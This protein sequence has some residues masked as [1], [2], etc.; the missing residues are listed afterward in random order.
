MG[1]PR[2]DPRGRVAAHHRTGTGTARIGYPIGIRTLAVRA[3]EQVTARMVRLTLA[4]PE[5]AGFHSY[6][7]DDHVKIVFPD[8]DGTRR[9]PVGNAEQTL[10]WPHPLPPA[11]KYTVRRHDPDAGELDLDFVLHP[12]GLASTWV[13]GVEPGEPVTVAGPPG[14][15]AFP[16]HYDHYVLAV[17]AT[18]LP[19]AAR[20]LDESPPEVSA[21]VVVEV[22]DPAEH[23][24]PLARRAGVRVHRL[25][26]EG[27][28]SSLAATVRALELPP[29]RTFLFAA[30]EAGDVKPLRRSGLDALVTGY[31]KRGVAGLDE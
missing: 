7:A 8:P 30:G 12:G 6:Q 22:D 15:V 10:D 1:G 21:Q 2:D 19:A 4:G 16:H 31:W 24:Y 11:R 20:W 14:A 3:R 17:D 27:G 26:R 23:E 9:V 18:A 5:L 25:V 13:Q 28:R 29:G